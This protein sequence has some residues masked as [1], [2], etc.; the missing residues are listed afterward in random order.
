MSSRKRLSSL[1]ANEVNNESYY[2]SWTGCIDY[3]V[4]W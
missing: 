1:R 3:Y 2:D 4:K